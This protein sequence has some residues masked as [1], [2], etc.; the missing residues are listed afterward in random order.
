MITTSPFAWVRSASDY[1]SPFEN[2]YS[3]VTEKCATGVYQGCLATM[4]LL[5]RKM[6]VLDV[7]TFSDKTS[8]PCKVYLYC[9]KYWA[10]EDWKYFT[11]VTNQ[12]FEAASQDESII[13]IEMRDH[14]IGLIRNGK[15]KFPG[16]LE[17]YLNRQREHEPTL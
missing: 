13:P 1:F 12:S 11:Q 8:T 9:K 17:W 4:E 15:T 14:F 16:G 2:F 3:E 10:S 7:K 6:I 5:G